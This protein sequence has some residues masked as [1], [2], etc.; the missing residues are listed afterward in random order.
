MGCN[1]Q[2]HACQ[3]PNL[4]EIEKS[5]YSYEIGRKTEDSHDKT[6]LIIEEAR[7]KLSSEAA[8]IIPQYTSSQCSV[9][10]IRKCN[11]IPKEP[12]TFA[13]ILIPLEY[14]VTTSN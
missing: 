8:A 10:C 13:D 12:T 7:V 5:I 2:S 11:N 3:A 4:E 9:Q 1:Y 6:R 14:Q